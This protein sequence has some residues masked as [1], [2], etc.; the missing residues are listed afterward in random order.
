MPLLLG[1]DGGGESGSSDGRQQQQKSVSTGRRSHAEGLQVVLLRTS[2]FP[3]RGSRNAEGGGRRVKTAKGACRAPLSLALCSRAQ[4]RL[5]HRERRPSH[6]LRRVGRPCHGAWGTPAAL[7][8]SLRIS[9]QHAWPHTVTYLTTTCTLPADFPFRAAGEGD[10]T[11]KPNP[12]CWNAREG[13][14]HGI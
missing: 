10:S 3:R 9:T 2:L 14:L 6:G 8:A 5:R 13:P 4:A 7:S 12:L 11:R 1:E